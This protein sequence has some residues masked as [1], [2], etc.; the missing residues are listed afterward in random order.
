MGLRLF[1]VHWLSWAFSL[2]V[3][4]MC[5]RRRWIFPGRADTGPRMELSP[6][7][8]LDDAKQVVGWLL[9]VTVTTANV[10]FV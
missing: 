10:P 2:G 6:D 7:G 1:R 3:Y 4:P 9:H 8:P 5:W